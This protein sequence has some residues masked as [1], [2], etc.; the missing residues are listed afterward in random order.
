[1]CKSPGR[2]IFL[3]PSMSGLLLEREGPGCQSGRVPHLQGKVEERP[4]D[5]GGKTDTRPLGTNRLRFLLTTMGRNVYSWSCQR[6]VVS[7]VSSVLIRKG[8]GQH[9]GAPPIPR[10]RKQL[11]GGLSCS[12][13]QPYNLCSP[14]T[15]NLWV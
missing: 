8:Q 4:T 5:T 15:N 13:T 3:Q 2:G 9:L 14:S 6:W 1:M 12:R 7:V 10:E 11:I